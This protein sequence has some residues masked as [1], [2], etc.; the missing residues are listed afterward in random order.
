MNTIGEIPSLEVQ[1]AEEGYA[2]LC[3]FNGQL[4][5]SNGHEIFLYRQNK[6]SEKLWFDPVRVYCDNNSDFIIFSYLMNTIAFDTI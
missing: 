2:H 5:A 6:N 1:A 4:M 3:L